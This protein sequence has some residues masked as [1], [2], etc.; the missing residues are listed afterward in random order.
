MNDGW[1]RLIIFL[2]GDPHLLEGGERGQDGASNP[3]RVFPLGRSDD[4]DFHGGWSQGSDLLLHS[5]S[6][7]REHGA[8]TGEDGVGVEVLTDVHIALHDGVVASLVDTSRLHTQEAG[9]EEGLGAP[10]SLV[11]D[12][13]HLTVRELVALLQAGAGRSSAHLLLEV[14]GNVAEFLLDV[15]DDFTL[16]SGGEGVATLGED[17]HEVVSQVT[18]S[19][20]QTEDGMGEGVTLVYGHSVRHTITRVKH[21]T[22]GTSRGVQGEHSLD[23]DVHGRG[24]EGLEH[25]LGHLLT[26]SLGVEG[27][28][29]QQH[30]VLLGSNTE[31]VVESVMPDLHEC[32]CIPSYV[33]LLEKIN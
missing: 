33:Q 14:K 9:L 30:R 20:V 22:S 16:S 4:L 12:G 15:T 8:A 24:V 11:S 21:D 25:D 6:N 18:T 31:L 13:D 3:Y 32:T 28:L 17:L 7:A 2:L 19:Q 10:E 23:G 27:S 26:V 1:P 5:V 29:G